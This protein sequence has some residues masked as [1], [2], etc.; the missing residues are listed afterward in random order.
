MLRNY[1]IA[2][3]LL[4]LLHVVRLKFLKFLSQRAFSVNKNFY[5]F[6]LVTLQLQT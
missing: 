6:Y 4:E 1:N 3:D 5:I 2:A